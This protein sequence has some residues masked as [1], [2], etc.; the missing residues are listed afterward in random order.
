MAQFFSDDQIKLITSL[1]NRIVPAESEFPG[2]GDLGVGEFL[3]GAVSGSPKSRRSFSAGLRAISM[4]AVSQYSREFESL[5]ADDQDDVL[6]IVESN[7]PE[8]FGELVRQTYNG[9]YINH[10]VIEALGLEARPPQPKGYPL[11]VGNL[12]L[13]ERVKARGT[14]YRVF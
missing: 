2:A 6:R 13:I 9:Y 14:A 3:D 11:E 12:E 5:S 7:Q 4:T 10:R 1:L 8:F